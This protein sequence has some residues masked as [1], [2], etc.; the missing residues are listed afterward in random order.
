M[1]GSYTH[2]GFAIRSNLRALEPTFFLNLELGEK[3]VNTTRCCTT[4]SF[5]FNHLKS[6]LINGYILQCNDQSWESC[7][8][9]DA[10]IPQCAPHLMI[11]WNG[12]KQWRCVV[13]TCGRDNFHH[14]KPTRIEQMNVIRRSTKIQLPPFHSLL[15]HKRVEQLQKKKSDQLGQSKLLS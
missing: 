11:E 4:R 3:F 7:A 15:D 9:Y 5:K 2:F 13:W 10:M 6:S 1:M 8:R 12:E 14:F